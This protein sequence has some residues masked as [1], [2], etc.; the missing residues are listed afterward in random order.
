MQHTCAMHIAR[1][2]SQQHQ[3]NRRVTRVRRYATTD[4][5]IAEERLRGVDH[6]TR[7]V[8]VTKRFCCIFTILIHVSAVEGNSCNTT[9]KKCPADK[10]QCWLNSKTKECKHC[11]QGHDSSGVSGL[12]GGTQATCHQCKKGKFRA[13]GS[14]KPCQP[15]SA[16]KFQAAEAKTSCG[17]CATGSI[18]NT[19]GKPG[20]SK[21]T[22]CPAGKYSSD[23][24]IQCQGM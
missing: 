5:T 22:K 12:E 23:S 10:P 14:D 19:L 24:K 3:R 7:V 1:S 9:K 18:T 8:M 15:C 20:A 17:S 4:E 11:P 21:C 13:K 2:C 16:G 6:Y